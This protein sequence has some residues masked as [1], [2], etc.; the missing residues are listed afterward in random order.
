MMVDREQQKETAMEREEKNRSTATSGTNGTTAAKTVSTASVGGA[1]AS[2]TGPR[3][4]PSA[5]GP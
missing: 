4:G 3:A 5:K 2:R 1:S